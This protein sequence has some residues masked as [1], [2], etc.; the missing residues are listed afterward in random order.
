MAIEKGS[1]PVVRSTLG[2]ND[3]VVMVPLILVLRKIDKVFEFLFATAKSSLPSPLISPT[4]ILR[5][6]KP[7]AKSTLVANDAVVML[8]LVLV[9]RNTDIVFTFKLEMTKSGLLSLFISPMATKYADPPDVKST[10]VANDAVVMVPL[11]LVL[12]NTDTVLEK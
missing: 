7:V 8:P 11:V 2:A 12:R 10:L 4:A 3:A 1:A 5:G 6:D 9:L